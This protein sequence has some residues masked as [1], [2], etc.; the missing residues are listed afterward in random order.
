MKRIRIFLL[1]WLISLLLASSVSFVKA[2]SNSSALYPV[3]INGARVENKILITGQVKN[4]SPWVA[5]DVKVIALFKEVMISGTTTVSAVASGGSSD[6][7]IALDYKQGMASFITYVSEYSIQSDDVNGLL[8]GYSKASKDSILQNA[9]PKAFSKMTTAARPALIKCVD[10]TARPAKSPANQTLLNDLMC[11]EGLRVMGDS[12]SA[13]AMLDLLAWHE[14][15]K[16]LDLV[17]IR[18]EMQTQANSPLKS[19]PVLTGL[20][21][22]EIN[23]KTVLARALRSMD[24]AIVPVLL[25]AKQ[26]SSP[27]VSQAANDVLVYLRKD[28]WKN[29][30]DENNPAILKEILGIIQE[31]GRSETVGLLLSLSESE[32]G[33]P[34]V[35]QVDTC[36]LSFRANAVQPLV[37]ALEDPNLSVIDH[38]ERLL[39][40]LAPNNL[41]AVQTAFTRRGLPL[42]SASLGPDEMI[43]ALRKNADAAVQTRI[44]VEF[45]RG[46]QLYQQGDCAGAV[47]VFKNLFALRLELPAYA[48]RLAQAYDCYAVDLYQHKQLDQALALAEQAFRLDALNPGIQVHL[49]N[50]YNTLAQSYV[51]AGNFDK[52]KATWYRVLDQDPDDPIARQGLGNLVLRQNGIYLALGAVFALILLVA[53]A[54]AHP[55][56]P[57]RGG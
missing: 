20:S 54:R 22:A 35:A 21:G 51:E 14:T 33:K 4:D 53:S 44:E 37:D 25:R 38:A 12:N 9:I 15:Q 18:T 17:G 36:I 6:F 31:M 41:P 47:N 40:L 1:S 19:F 10:L 49:Q 52:A 46:W 42:P 29:L 11:L 55:L 5:K 7:V 23:L 24:P 56:E 26:N 45:A 57:G 27:A 8:A 30:L 48:S 13:K 32:R 16:S 50:L 2:Q 34:F 39:R 3:N 28:T 43:S